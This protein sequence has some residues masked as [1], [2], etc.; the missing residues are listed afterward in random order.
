MRRNQFRKG[1]K[2]NFYSNRQPYDKSSSYDRPASV[3]YEKGRSVPS[4]CTPLK[5]N[6][7]GGGLDANFI[8]TSFKP[9]E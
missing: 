9:R 2:F 5:T 4:M 3:D 8:N 6:G 1:N 7:Y